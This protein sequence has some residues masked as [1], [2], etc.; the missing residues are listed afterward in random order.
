MADAPWNNLKLTRGQVAQRLDALGCKEIGE[1]SEDAS[2][3]EA[4][5]GN[6]FT[7]SY[8]DCDAEYLEGIVVQL[9]RW[10]DE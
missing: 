10:L 9:Q 3:W 7:M 5:T 6:V 4:P 8:A 1:I 2:M